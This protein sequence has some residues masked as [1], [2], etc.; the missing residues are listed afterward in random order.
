MNHAAA[1][2]VSHRPSQLLRQAD[3]V[4]HRERLYH[5]CQARFATI[6]QNDRPG[7]ARFVEHLRHAHHPAHPLEECQLMLQS[8]LTVWTPAALCG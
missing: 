5:L 6:R 7:I 8:A 1:V 3:Q 4:I 2:H